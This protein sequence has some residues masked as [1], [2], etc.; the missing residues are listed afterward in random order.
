[1]NTF[2]YRYFINHPDNKDKWET[3]LFIRYDNI[4]RKCL[5]YLNN[6]QLESRTTTAGYSI[7]ELQELVLH[8]KLVEAKIRVFT[9][10]DAPMYLIESINKEKMKQVIYYRRYASSYSNI[11]D[12]QIDAILKEISEKRY[13]EFTD[14]PI[15]DLEPLYLYIKKDDPLRQVLVSQSRLAETQEIYRKCNNPLSENYI[16][17]FLGNINIYTEFSMTN[18]QIRKYI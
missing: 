2:R 17:I 9:Y 12:N 8:N 3:I 16:E 4:D 18:S 6:S 5:Y 15:I 14:N 13:T 1:M 11:D 10:A 7:D